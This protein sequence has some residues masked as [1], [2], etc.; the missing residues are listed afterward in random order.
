M[1]L[2]QRH[3]FLLILVLMLSVIMVACGDGH[4]FTDLRAY[5]NSLRT[6]KTPASKKSQQVQG[7][8][9]QTPDKATYKAKERRMPF[10]Q[11]Q[12][13][14]GGQREIT[15]PLQ[16]YPLNMLRFVGTITHEQGAAS[17]AY[18]AAPDGITREV[19]VGDVIGDRYGTVVSI[20]SNQINVREE[21]TEA[22]KGVT[23]RIVTLQLKESQ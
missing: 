13:I 1:R 16:A 11:T 6:A 17:T 8:K 2:K 3:R 7:P 10:G 14:A 18:I 23:E 19:K 22:G 4:S 15:N 12:S 20:G 5:I 21:V 9:L